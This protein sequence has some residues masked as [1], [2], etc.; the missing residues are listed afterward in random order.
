[1]QIAYISLGFGVLGIASAS[2]IALMLS[3]RDEGTEKMSEIAGYIKEGANAFLQKE[4]RFLLY[5]AILLALL[6]WLTIGWQNALSFVV[7]SFSSAL[8]GYV[9][10]AVSL[11]ANVRSAAA[12]LKGGIRPAFSA[13]Y[14]GGAVMG[15]F[16]VGIALFGISSLYL[17]FGD[18][19][20]MVGY[21]FGASL[22]SLLLRVG[23]GI[24]TKGAD[25]GSDIVGKV[26]AGIPEDDPRNPGV[27]ADN[28][29]DNV[30]DCA[31]MGA[32]LFETY[33][34]T[35]IT[36]MLLGK[37]LVSIHGI[38][39][40]FAIQLPLLLG[41]LA[42]LATLIGIPFIR[43]GK[44][45]IMSAF[46]KGLAV[47]A[48]VVIV[49]DYFVIGGHRGI[50]EAI[51]IGVL[52]LVAMYIFAEYFTS[53]EFKPVKNVA[54]KSQTGA[55]INIITGMANGLKS[56]TVPVLVVAA[57]VLFVFLLNGGLSSSAV[58]FYSGV[59]AVALSSV[60]MI[61]LAGMVISIDTFGPIAD[62]AGGIA[63][64]ADLP[65]NVRL[66]ATDPLDSVGNTTKATTK[67]YA[68]ASAALA[69]MSLFVAFD[70][71]LPKSALLQLFVYNPLVL[72]GLFIGAM[73][74]FLFT[75]M[76]M[77]AVGITAFDIV[78]EIRRQFKLPGIID[79]TT[80]PDYARCVGI[81][82]ESAMKQLLLPG[83]LA[84]GAPLAVGFVLGPLALSGYMFGAIITGFPMAIWMTTGGGAWD[85]AKKYVEKGMYGGKNSETH[86]A[87]VV[88]DTVGD[89]TKD[90]A[91][92]AVNP[93]IKVI[94]TVSV[95]FAPL[96]I[97]FHLLRSSSF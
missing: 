34:V 20:D 50:F 89:A 30:G 26:E 15:L 32:D 16:V 88:G 62:N 86:K 55:A 21:M 79:G 38:P 19:I 17:V 46:Y 52:V 71:E 94:M 61:S 75:S 14:E 33:A 31:G 54:E 95:L 64:M 74:P 22:V 8:A 85:N 93:L 49:A 27:I 29:G 6:V 11:K 91:G 3:R 63:E 12:A 84:A 13:A 73:V 69:T 36:A 18:P 77:E 2:G 35:I 45:R 97:M 24:Y 10:I 58:S 51:V 43:L 53:Y 72:I 87:T 92:P 81:T 65:E 70:L 37:L 82:T 76:L 83:L 1:M 60:S 4:M 28:V 25:I 59:Y 5:G 41:G 56:T 47:S 96:I 42:V 23:G 80:K 48:A 57:A 39:E 78:N 68:I 9:G 7:G 66:N 40:S 67:A 90:T 44:G